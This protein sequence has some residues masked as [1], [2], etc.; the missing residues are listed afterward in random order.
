MRASLA[1]FGTDRV[2]IFKNNFFCAQIQH[3]LDG[4]DHARHE[5]LALPSST[6]VRHERR[7][8]DLSS[9]AVPG[10]LP[11]NSISFIDKFF[12]RLSDI[13][14]MISALGRSDAG[15]EGFSGNLNKFLA[16]YIYFADWHRHRHVGKHT[17][18]LQT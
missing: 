11:N 12:Y 6:V 5:L 15:L 14:D 10:E 13:S 17:L 9:H 3:R 7:F 2:I 1:V 16:L 18:V 4:D 8:M